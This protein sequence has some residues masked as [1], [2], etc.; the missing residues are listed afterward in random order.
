[1]KSRLIAAMLAASLGL[2]AADAA[3]AHH[4]FAAEF[5]ADF[6]AGLADPSRQRKGFNCIRT[7]ANPWFKGP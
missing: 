2:A 5:D 1:M 6:V 4:S 3:V 7:G